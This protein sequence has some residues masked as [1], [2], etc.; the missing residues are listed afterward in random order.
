MDAK[1]CELRDR[2]TVIIGN[3]SLASKLSGL[4]E[5]EGP[6][7]ASYLEKCISA[8]EQALEV[9]RA[10]KASVHL[11]HPSEGVLKVAVQSS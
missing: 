6:Q 4:Q 7:I 10:P 2:L 5:F 3:A 9:V 11:L 1:V 8:A